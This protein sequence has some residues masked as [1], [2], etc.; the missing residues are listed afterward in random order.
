MEQYQALLGLAAILTQEKQ[1]NSKPLEQITYF[2]ERSVLFKQLQHLKVAT[3]SHYLYI[4]PGTF[5]TLKFKINC[6]K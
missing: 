4:P 5:G 2:F 6:K 1:N 3:Y